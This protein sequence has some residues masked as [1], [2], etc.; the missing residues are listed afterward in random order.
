[1]G[2]QKQTKTKKEEKIPFPQ[3]Q[4]GRGG[5]TPQKNTWRYC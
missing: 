4:V 2:Q 5:K 1:M 3:K